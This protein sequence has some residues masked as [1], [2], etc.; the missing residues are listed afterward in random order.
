MEDEKSCHRYDAVHTFRDPENAHFRKFSLKSVTVL[1]LIRTRCDHKKIVC[2]KGKVFVVA[3]LV[4]TRI[5][6][7]AR[8]SEN[9]SNLTSSSI[10][11]HDIVD[12]L[13]HTSSCQ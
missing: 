12:S 4:L 7:T 10:A 3:L 8:E 9:G 11:L 13:R 6:T 1:I 5:N 2:K